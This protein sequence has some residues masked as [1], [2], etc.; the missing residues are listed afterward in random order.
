MDLTVYRQLILLSVLNIIFLFSGMVLN[1]L[2]IVTVLKSR[3]LRN[4]PCHFMIMVLSCCDLLSVVTINSEFVLHLILRLTE[5]YDLLTTMTKYFNLFSLSGGISM[6]ALLVM[7]IERYIGA[8]HPIFHRT[9]VNRRRLVI[10]FAIL[11]I[12]PTTLTIISTDE[13]VISFSVALAIFLSTYLPP[14]LFINCKLF[15]ISKKMRRNNAASSETRRIRLKNINACLLVVV[16]QV[17]LISIPLSLQVAFSLVEGS[18]SDNANL[19]SLWFG[20]TFVTNCSCNSLIF[21]WKNKI[22]YSE[23]LKIIKKLKDRTVG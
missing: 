18:M 14:F 3:K 22:L 2:V 7:C 13:L 4:R 6:I 17:F 12:L 21:F 19:A 1:T 9:S 15:M 11:I 20:T 10:F 23:G 8:Y 5:N 16:C